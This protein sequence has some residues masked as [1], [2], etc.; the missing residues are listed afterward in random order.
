M[1]IEIAAKRRRR[2]SLTSLID[3]IFLLLLFF[4]LSS[5]FTRFAEVDIVAGRAGEGV[6]AMQLPDVFI[7]L[8]SEQGWKVNGAQLA[9]DDAL[10]ELSRL[11]AGGARTA[12]IVVRENVTSQ[13]LVEAIERI[14]SR[15]ELQLSVA[16]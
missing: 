16:G 4:M 5:T 2:L 12:L 7:R 9:V 15:V 10:E 1:R 13:M 11:E 6:S 14:G 8:D 3:V